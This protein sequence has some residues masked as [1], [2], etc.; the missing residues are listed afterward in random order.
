MARDNK[1]VELRLVEEETAVAAPVI[2]LRNEETVQT[3]HEEPPILLGGPAEGADVSHRLDCPSREEIEL[4]THQPGI[5]VIIETDALNPNFLE[6]KW[7]EASTFKQPIPWGWFALICLSIAGAVVWSLNDVKKAELQIR[8]VRE[9]AAS[10][11]RLEAEKKQ[12]AIQLV[13]QIDK[14]LRDFFNVTSVEGL[15]RFVR[16]P[17]RVIPL[18]RQYYANQAVFTGRLRRIHEI[19]PLTLMDRGNFWLASVE[20]SNEKPQNLII[21]I[22]ASGEA[23]IDW[24]SLV[25]AQ[26]MK[27]DDY[28]SHKPAGKSLDFRVY[29]EPDN[30]FSHEFQDEKRWSCYLLTAMKSEQILFGYVPAKSDLDQHLRREIK[31][32]RKRKT[33]LILRLNSPEN[34]QAPNGVLIEAILSDH[35]FYKDPPEAPT[36]KS[37]TQD[38]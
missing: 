8:R 30:F 14:T 38:P 29:V 11:L 32:N 28:V 35:W 27:W 31:R 24:E 2:R 23:R 13:D 9:E 37:V 19:R 6:Q 12:Q 15:T 34:I 17:E 25:C 16:Q 4:R 18:M 22:L 1:P 7:G 5:D 21:E 36:K 20:R 10:T 33:A 26:P 3:D